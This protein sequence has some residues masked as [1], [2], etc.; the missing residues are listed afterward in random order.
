MKYLYLYDHLILPFYIEKQS[1][2]K[3]GTKMPD[4]KKIYIYTKCSLNYILHVFIQKKAA[5]QLIIYL[6]N[7]YILIHQVIR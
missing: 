3:V 1:S 2:G 4:F 7:I 5:C 6:S